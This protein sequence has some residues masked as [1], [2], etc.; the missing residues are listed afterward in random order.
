M[1]LRFTRSDLATFAIGVV[2]TCA[3]VLAEAFSGVDSV[4]NLTTWWEG[5][6]VGLLTSLGRYVLT[7]LTSRGFQGL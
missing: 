2:A 6:R 4:T 3:W 7:Y 1:E 5:L